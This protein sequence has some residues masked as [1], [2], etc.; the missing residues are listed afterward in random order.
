MVDLAERYRRAFSPVMPMETE[1]E[2][3]RGEGSYLIA[4]DGRRYLDLATGIAVNAVGYG[5]TGVQAA[6]AEQLGRNLHLYHG[7]GYQEVVVAYAEALLSH[8]EGQNRLFFA[9]SGAEAV[10]AAIKLARYTTGRP[11]LVAFRGAFHGRTLGAVSLTASAARYRSAY[12]PLLPS[13]YHVDYPAPT[14]LGLDPDGALMHV[15]AQVRSLLDTEVAPDHVAAVVVE[16]IQGE[17]GYV[18]PPDGFLPWLREL[19]REYGILLVADEVQ[20]GMGRTGR[21]SAYE[22]TGIRPDIVVMGKAVGGGL[23]LSAMIAPAELMRAWQ[24]GVH[25][26]TFGGNPLACAAGLATLRAIESEGLMAHAAEMGALALER[27]SPLSALGEVR[28]VRGRGLMVAVEFGGDRR[29]RIVGE[30]IRRG[31]EAGMVMHAAGLHHEVLR[32]MP[33]LNIERDV[34]SEALDRLAEIVRATVAAPVGA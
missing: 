20:S 26:S 21:M 10:E 13:V 11:A 4:A 15:Q 28:D 27:L 18:I 33:P 3:E 23:P 29:D 25:G 17:G 12:E 30:V 1:L 24:A 19:S 32:L 2:I 22:H 8:F 14:R 5:H 31:V 6:I 9:N 7:T 34:L 16:A